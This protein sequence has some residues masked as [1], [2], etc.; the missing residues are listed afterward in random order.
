MTPAELKS[1]F[2]QYVDEPDQSFMT[3]TNVEDYLRQGYREFR[4]LVLM[5]NPSTY[6]ASVNITITVSAD[7]YELSS[8]A[9]AAGTVLGSNPGSPRMVMLLGVRQVE[10]ASGDTLR[11]LHGLPS[12][13]ALGT[14]PDGYFL[15]GSVLRLPEKITGTFAIDYAPEG[16]VNWSAG[17]YVD[18]LTDWHDLIALYATRTYLIRDQGQNPMLLG[19]IATRERDFIRYIQERDVDAARYVNEIYDASGG[20]W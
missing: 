20:S 2:R 8:A 17:T 7:S 6:Q 15:D 3:D 14:S 5:H 12:R 18:D 1:L 13:R 19:Q 9:G 4:Q 10:P 16:L 11:N